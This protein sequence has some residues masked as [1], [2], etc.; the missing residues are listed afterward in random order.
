MKFKK[1]GMIPQH[2]LDQCKH[3]KKPKYLAKKILKDQT[4]QSCGSDP[5]S[6]AFLSPG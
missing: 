6:G 2:N 4:E 3:A 1:L 5:G